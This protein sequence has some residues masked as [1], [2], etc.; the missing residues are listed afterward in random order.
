MLIDSTTKSG[1]TNF[2]NLLHCAR[3]QSIAGAIS[4]NREKGGRENVGLCLIREAECVTVLFCWRN[5]FYIRPSCKNLVSMLV[6]PHRQWW[7]SFGKNLLRYSLMGNSLTIRSLTY[8][9]N[10]KTEIDR[11]TLQRIAWPRSEYRFYFDAAHEL[12]TV[13]LLP[14]QIKWHCQSTTGASSSNSLASLPIKLSSRV[15]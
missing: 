14:K 2:N 15:K 6:Y 12:P 7:G 1:L 5:T 3:T 10:S 4:E 9:M 13:P 8:Y 11:N